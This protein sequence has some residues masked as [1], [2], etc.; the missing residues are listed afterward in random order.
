MEGHRDGGGRTSSVRGRRGRERGDTDRNHLDRELQ[1]HDRGFAKA[2]MNEQPGRL[3][4]ACSVRVTETQGT[5]DCWAEDRFAK[6]REKKR[7]NSVGSKI[8]K[9]TK[10]GGCKQKNP[11]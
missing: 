10:R 3:W 8:E 9:S 6:C 4:Q 2:E 5:L 11:Q 1:R 7:I